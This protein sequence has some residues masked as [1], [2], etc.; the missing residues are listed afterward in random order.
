MLT[1]TKYEGYF[2]DELGNVYSNKYMPCIF[3]QSRRFKH[4]KSIYLTHI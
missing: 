2:V 1:E 4:E 3:K